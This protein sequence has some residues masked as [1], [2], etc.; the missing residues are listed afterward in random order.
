MQI[1]LNRFWQTDTLMVNVYVL[2]ARNLVSLT[3]EGV[4][5]GLRVRCTDPEW[6]V[7]FHTGY[8]LREKDRHDVA[9]L[10]ARFGLELPETYRA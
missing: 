5:G 3:G 9:A 10:C 8:P 2:T 7:R 4:I 6:L 1:P